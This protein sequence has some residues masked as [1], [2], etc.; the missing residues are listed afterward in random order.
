MKNT[1]NGPELEEDLVTAAKGW[2]ETT[3][4][5][6]K[7]VEE[8]GTRY[9]EEGEDASGKVHAVVSTDR[10]DTVMIESTLRRFEKVDQVHKEHFEEESQKVQQQSLEVTDTA[11]RGAEIADFNKQTLDSVVGEDHKA[12]A[13]EA[14]EKQE[15]KRI[16]LTELGQKGDQ[17][18]R[19]IA[20]ERT[21]IGTRI[22]NASQSG[23][24]H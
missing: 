3:E 19:D 9:A 17:Q 6:K 16:D 18:Q 2:L 15:R 21:K 5:N 22:Q 13:Q 24:S 4:E 8:L 11:K 10:Q 12:K 7:N 14:V 20:D 1:L 23:G